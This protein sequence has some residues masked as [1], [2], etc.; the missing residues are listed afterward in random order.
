MHLATA[1]MRDL[2]VAIDRPESDMDAALQCEGENV[3]LWGPP[4]TGKTYGA[5]HLHASKFSGGVYATTVT[6]DTPAAE[7]RGFFIPKPDPKTGQPGMGW[8]DGLAAK[9]MGKVV[10]EDGQTKIDKPTCRFVINEIH[11]KGPDLEA[12]IHAVCDDR[13]VA[14]IAL[15]NGDTVFAQPDLQ[16]VAT[17]NEPLDQPDDPVADRFAIRVY[18][19][20]PSI[21]AIVSLSKDLQDFALKQYLL[22]PHDPKFISFRR[23]SAFDRMRNRFDSNRAANLVFGALAEEILNAARTAGVHV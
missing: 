16:V 9:V 1:E 19:R 17:A 15:P 6:L 14:S 5:I 4:G 22:E 20:Y 18:V 10:T 21:V 7:W 8:Q 13:S 23:M 3:L 2:L 11:K 12:L